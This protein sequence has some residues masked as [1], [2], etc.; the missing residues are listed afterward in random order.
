[1]MTQYV[2]TGCDNDVTLGDCTS[3]DCPEVYEP[4][5]VHNGAL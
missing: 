1:M 3:E 4:V 2:V 5:N